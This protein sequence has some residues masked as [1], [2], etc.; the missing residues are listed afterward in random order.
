MPQTNVTIDH[1]DFSYCTIGY[2]RLRV[3]VFDRHPWRLTEEQQREYDRAVAILEKM[4]AVAKRLGGNVLMPT[5]ENYSTV[6]AY[7]RKDVADILRLVRRNYRVESYWN[8]VGLFTL[9]IAI[10][11]TP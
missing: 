9:S 11:N 8:G 2:K 7:T 5:K 4:K 3:L 10:E 1:P 6:E